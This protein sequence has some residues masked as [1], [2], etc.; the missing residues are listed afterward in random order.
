MDPYDDYYKF[1]IPLLCGDTLT[2]CQLKQVLAQ[3][4]TKRKGARNFCIVIRIEKSTY[5]KVPFERSH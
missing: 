3:L 2:L 1:F 4:A 5:T